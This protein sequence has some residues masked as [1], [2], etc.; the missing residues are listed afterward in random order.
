MDNI[1]TDLLLNLSSEA[2]G[3]IVT[4]FVIDQL[5]KR[6]EAKKWLPAKKYA[7]A[8]LMT[9]LDKFLN[10]ILSSVFE[11]E[12]KG[13][14]VFYK[15]GDVPVLGQASYKNYN[16]INVVKQIQYQ[17]DIY[18]G[19]HIAFDFEPMKHLSTAIKNSIVT[20]SPVFSPELSSVL[21]GLDNHIS[22]YV[23]K[24]ND[25]NSDMDKTMQSF[26][27]VMYKIVTLAIEARILVEKEA[28]KIVSIKEMQLESQKAIDDFKEYFDS[29]NTP[30]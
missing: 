12:T 7:H 14:S 27:F 1:F 9:E 25:K 23:H 2:I 28:D 16:P 19:L 22:E 17:A 26:S 13:E 8:H 15:Y 24:M 18:H 20:S 10:H 3:I 29:I 4:V 5:A 11:Y 30:K 6:R 21:I